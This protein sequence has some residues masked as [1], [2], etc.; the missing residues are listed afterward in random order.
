MQLV[1]PR[2]RN[3]TRSYQ[4]FYGTM[5]TL[6]ATVVHNVASNESTDVLSDARDKGME[7]DEKSMLHQGI[8]DNDRQKEFWASL[9]MSHKQTQA[10]EQQGLNDMF[11]EIEKNQTD[12]AKRE[13][14]LNASPNIK[15]RQSIDEH[16]LNILESSHDKIRD[17]RKELSKEERR[18]IELELKN[19]RTP[20]WVEGANRILHPM[21]S[22][23]SQW[24]IFVSA[25]IIYSV[26]TI[27]LS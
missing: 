7:K 11:S 23:K 13:E 16:A 10:E 14:F 2:I 24:D 18:I 9:S 17:A 6:A 20:V 3:E 26:Y 27:Q 15:R 1:L 8:E 12:R 21:S 4:H 5:P 25:W 19:K 22:A